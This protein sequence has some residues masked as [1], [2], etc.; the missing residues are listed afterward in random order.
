M[1]QRFAA[2]QMIY[3]MANQIPLLDI[4]SPM[5]QFEGEGQNADMPHASS[6]GDMVGAMHQ[7]R[8][9]MAPEHPEAMTVMPTVVAF[10]DPNDLL[11]Y[12]LLPPMLD[13]SRARLINVI[14]S[15]ETTWLGI[16]ERPDTAHC[17]YAWNETVIAMIARG[18]RA[19]EPVPE[20]PV[21]GP[22]RCS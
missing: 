14:V 5:A 2:V 12:R 21:V 9:T 7:S 16:L 4:A 1:S 22:R 13:I 8:M 18:H 6:L 19:G 3:L 10:T 15:N 17:G 11:N 20:V